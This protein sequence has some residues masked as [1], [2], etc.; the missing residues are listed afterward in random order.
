MQ[1]IFSSSA[2]ILRWSARLL[3][4]MIVLF[5]GFFLLANLFGTAERSTR[6][7]IWADYVMLA[8]IIIA[9]AGLATAWKW[10]LLGASI[11]LIAF[12]IVAAINWRVVIFPGTLIPSTALLFLASWWIHRVPR[13]PGTLLSNSDS[14]T[15]I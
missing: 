7:L 12:G 13:N 5:W 6:P 1:F 2:N 11:T 4:G 15:K 14:A 10:E 8:G 9:V 3:S